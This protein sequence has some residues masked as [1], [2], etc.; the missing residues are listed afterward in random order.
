MRSLDRQISGSSSAK[1]PVLLPDMN[2]RVRNLFL[3]LGDKKT[4]RFLA[5][6]VANNNFKIF[7]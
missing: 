6:V 2:Q 4:G 7:V 3:K 1:T 5:A